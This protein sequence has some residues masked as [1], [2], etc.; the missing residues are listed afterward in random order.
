MH[1]AHLQHVVNSIIKSMA[2]VKVMPRKLQIADFP[3]ITTISDRF[4][5][6]FCKQYKIA[7]YGTVSKTS[8]LV[9]RPIF[10]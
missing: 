2:E 8:D 1:A 5:S 6:T 7:K 9:M 3:G 4:H 10:T